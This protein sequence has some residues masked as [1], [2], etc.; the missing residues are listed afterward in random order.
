MKLAL[1]GGGGFRVPLVYGALLRDA[2]ERRVEQVWL[3]DTDPRRLAVM[4]HVLAQLASHADAAGAAGAP[5]PPRVHATTRLDEAVAGADFVFS[6]MRVGGLAGRTC[7]ERVALDLGV[8]GQETTGPG[9]LAYGLRTIP[10]ALAVAHAVDAHAPTAYVIN[11]TNPAG[12]ITEAMTGVLGERVIGICDSPLGLARRA[13]RVA[14]R[15]LGELRLDYLG[16]NHLGWLRGMYD[17]DG[18]DLLPE[19]LGSDAALAAME[20]GRLFGADWLRTIGALPNEYLYYWYFTRDALAQIRGAAQTRGE[21]LLAQQS[22]FYAAAAADPDS[23]LAAWR[24]CRDEREATYLA[25]ARAAGESRDEEDLAGGG[26]EGVALA[27]MGAIA[28]GEPATMILNVAAGG[29]VPGLPADAV[30]EVPCAVG[31]SGVRPF[32]D[33]VTPL[34][35]H[36]LGLVQQMKAVERLTIEA[37]TQRSTRLAVAA[38]AQHPLVDSVTVAR[39][40]LD[41]YRAVI[42]EVDALFRAG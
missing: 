5:E 36:M 34:A 17:G 38:F 12:M 16:L 27:L 3:H 25:E 30:V 39:Q 35:G 23:A 21:F 40:L 31:A 8:L 7:D 32:G 33:S 19:V 28:R 14:G 18:R 11:F 10:V 42:P 37:A 20:E 41:G 2:H 22:A 4:E 29:L 26:Y 13:A 24:R 9:G 6:A 1:L 15:D